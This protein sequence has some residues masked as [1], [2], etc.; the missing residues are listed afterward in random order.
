MPINHTLQYFKCVIATGCLARSLKV[1]PARKMS[2]FAC[3]LA[4]HVATGI[5]KLGISVFLDMKHP[6]ETAVLSEH[7]ERDP[8]RE[9]VKEIEM[10]LQQ[11]ESPS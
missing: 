6:I 4:K 10:E 9:R 7:T 5:G 11:R 1:H 2:I 3:N 8:W